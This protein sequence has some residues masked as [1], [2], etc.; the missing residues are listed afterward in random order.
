MEEKEQ[1]WEEENE[2]LKDRI[3]KLRDEAEEKDKEIKRVRCQRPRKQAEF[4]PTYGPHP[5]PKTTDFNPFLVP[6]NLWTKDKLMEYFQCCQKNETEKFPKLL[7]IID[8]YQ[9]GNKISLKCEF[10]DAGG[11]VITLWLPLTFV[12][13]E[14]KYYTM[15][16]AWRR[17]L[18]AV[19]TSWDDFD[20]IDKRDE[21]ERLEEQARKDR[22]RKQ[23]IEE[24]AAKKQMGVNGSVVRPI[25]AS[26]PSHVRVK[27]S[28]CGP[29]SS[30]LVKLDLH[31][32]KAQPERAT[33][34]QM[35][36]RRSV[37]RPIP[38]SKP[39]HVC[40]KLSTCGPNS[41]TLVKLN[42]QP[43]KAQPRVVVHYPKRE[44]FCF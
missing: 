20:K 31:P 37:P 26:K 36:L 5:K 8:E 32:V 6:G 18:N 25:T 16:Q 23:E 12:Y 10:E 43:V 27:L 7:K 39:S 13:N 9:M 41:S 34:K 42:L 30:T 24:R 33:K 14:K 2:W 21:K 29:N 22:K 40:V 19:D 28:T 17:K 1:S 38:V 44:K 4:K 35:G 3:A 15:W 11:N